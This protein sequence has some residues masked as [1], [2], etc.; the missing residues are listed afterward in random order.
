M[1][2]KTRNEELIKNWGIL[3]NVRVSSFFERFLMP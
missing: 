2:V 3:D 1:L